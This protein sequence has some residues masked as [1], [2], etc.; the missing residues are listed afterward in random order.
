MLRRWLDSGRVQRSDLFIVTKLPPPGNRAACVEK[1]LRG[2]LRDLQLDY[3]DLYLIHT[4]FSVP[5]TDGDFQR[6]ANGDIVLDTDTDHAA[7]WLRLEEMVAAGL[8][9]SIGVSN[10]N[11]AQ[12]QRLL[13]GC[14]ARDGAIRPVNL[15]IECHIYLQQHELVDFC[16]ENGVV[17]TAYAPLGSKG[18]EALNKMAGIE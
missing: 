10:F 5:E 12:L 2:S 18:I 6:H 3:I 13:N 17:V 9:R 16:R 4:P 8:C 7:T 14:A 11:R 1:Y 15:Q